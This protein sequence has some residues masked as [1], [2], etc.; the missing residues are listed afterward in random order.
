MLVI[1]D[2][3]LYSFLTYQLLRIKSQYGLS[4]KVELERWIKNIFKP[5]GKPHFVIL[6]VSPINQIKQRIIKREGS[7]NR[8]E[9][10][11]IEKVQE[12]YRKI[13]KDHHQPSIILKNRNG[14]FENVKQKVIRQIEILIKKK[15][16]IFY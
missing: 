16:M 3:G 9:V 10:Y 8:Q 7:I 12:E 2:R 13:L 6:L 11:F 14:Q 15:P 4:I 5:I 1:S